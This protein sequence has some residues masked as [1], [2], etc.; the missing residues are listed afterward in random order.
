VDGV[1]K[2]P[3]ISALITGEIIA[4][5]ALTIPLAIARAFMLSIGL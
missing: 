4:L 1:V 5:L 2:D 3:V